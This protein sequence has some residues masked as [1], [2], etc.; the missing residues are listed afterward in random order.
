MTG[1]CFSLAPPS[2]GACGD[3]CGGPAPAVSQGAPLVS[4]GCGQDG[5][6]S[7]ERGRKAPRRP[8]HSHV[9]TR[10]TDYSPHVGRNDPPC[11]DEGSGGMCCR[12][13]DRRIKIY[14]LQCSQH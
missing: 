11:H 10:G 5:G 13:A 14:G 8:E 2:C 4:G 3:E 7:M 6:G 12:D 1:R 9:C